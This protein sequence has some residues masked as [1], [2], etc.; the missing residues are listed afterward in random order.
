MIRTLVTNDDG[1]HSVGL[2]TLARTAVS[3]GLEVVVAA[4]SS[5]YSGSSA[6]LTALE[7]HGRLVARET[8]LPHVEARRCL[9]VEAT[10]AFIAMAA[11]AGAFGAPPQL[12]LAGVNHGPNTGHAL[13]HSGTLGAALT[14]STHGCPAV[15]VSLASA[16]PSEFE[17][18]GAVVRR[19][20]EWVLAVSPLRSVVLNVN[21][22]NVPVS[23]LRGLRV[24]RLAALGAV[25]AHVAERGEDFVTM[26]FSEL[27]PGDAPDS[28]AALLA[29]G[30]A[31]VTAVTAPCEVPDADLGGL[32]GPGDG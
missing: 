30:W 3:A 11:S 25:Q 4:P 21:V 6:S 12:L 5:E 23:E 26:T 18:A 29:R 27:G 24:A 16:K 28:D 10:P 8:A 15:A 13:L 2:L 9:A 31:T 32:A 7:S 19:V 20:L 17:T 14:A 22:P 1:V